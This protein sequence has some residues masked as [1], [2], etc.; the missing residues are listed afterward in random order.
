MRAFDS[1]HDILMTLPASLFSYR[2]TTRRDVNVVFVP[3]GRE[4]V[5]MPETILRLGCIFADETG[6]RVTIV[7]NRHRTM[8]RLQPTTK[9]VLHNMTIHT[10]FSVVSHIGIP[11]GVNEGVGAHTYRHADRDTE[12]D[13][14]HLLLFWVALDT[15]EHRYIAQIH[16]MFEWFISLMATFTLAIRQPAKVNRM[17]IRA[18]LH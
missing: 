11:A 6:R 3:A 13:F 12:D 4:V 2:A 15:L 8:A 10:R 18:E 17:L 7:A 5:R 9:L 16:R 14:K 1:L